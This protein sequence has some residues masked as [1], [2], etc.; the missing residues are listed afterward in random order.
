MFRIK[1]SVVIFALVG[2]VA[3]DRQWA[4]IIIR[5]RYP[6]SEI[7]MTRDN[8]FIVRKPSGGSTVLHSDRA[9]VVISASDG[10]G[11]SILIEQGGDQ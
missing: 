10:G 5:E 2:L 3:C 8:T 7:W 9:N 4:R 1:K 6:D 11:T